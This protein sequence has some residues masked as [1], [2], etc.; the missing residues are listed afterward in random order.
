MHPEIMRFM[1]DD[2][3]QALRRDAR[4][5]VRTPRAAAN[6]TRDIELRLCKPA[7]DEQLAELALLSE[8]ALPA[9][10]L[11][12]ASVRNRIVAALP[13]AGG[14]ALRDPF[15]RTAHLLPLLELRAAQ[16]REPKPRRRL[17]PRYVSLIRGATHA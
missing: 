1:A 14:E 6:D 15:V 10:R 17:I 7:D 11:I 3:I 8:R 2:H 4:P 13:L 9:G 12:V 16:L 5:A